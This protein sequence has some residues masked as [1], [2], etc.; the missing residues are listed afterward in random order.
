MGSPHGN[1]FPVSE[2]MKTTERFTRLNDDMMLYEIKTEDPVIL[3]RSWTAR[4]PLQERSDLRVVGVRV[5][6]RQPH[7]SATTSARRA[8][9]ARR[10]R[11]A[12]LGR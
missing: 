12:G 4:Y 11:R 2:Q 3:T 7:D 10:R 1:R 5:P 6:R 9:S 8:P